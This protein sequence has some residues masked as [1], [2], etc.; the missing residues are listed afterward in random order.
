MKK[1]I[2]HDAASKVF[3]ATF[4]AAKVSSFAAT[5]GAKI[6]RTKKNLDFSCVSFATNLWMDGEIEPLLQKYN[7]DAASCTSTCYLLQLTEIRQHSKRQKVN[8][9]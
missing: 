5:G 7:K 3:S 9:S 4:F 6:E 1:L 2:G 8:A